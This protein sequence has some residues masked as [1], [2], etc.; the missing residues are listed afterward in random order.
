MSEKLIR[1]LIEEIDRR[2]EKEENK[3]EKPTCEC[4]SLEKIKDKL[5]DVIEN[6][7]SI[8][9]EVVIIPKKLLDELVDCVFGDIDE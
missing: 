1:T 2:L 4:Y 3:T 8:Y 7:V 9:E 5:D 6:G